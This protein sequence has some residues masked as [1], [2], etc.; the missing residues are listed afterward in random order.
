M[1]VVVVLFTAK[2][3]HVAHLRG[4]LIAQAHASLERE[5][6]CKRFDVCEDP[7]DAASF[8]LYEIYED[9]DAFKLHLETDHFHAFNDTVTPWVATKRVLTYDLVSDHG[10]A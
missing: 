6:G 9:E 5:S 4:A 2:P 8:L 1:H 10:L 3:A 7:T